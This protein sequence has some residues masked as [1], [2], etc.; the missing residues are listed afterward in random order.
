[1]PLDGKTPPNSLLSSPALDVQGRVS[2]NGRWLAYASDESGE[3]EVYVTQFPP[4]GGKWQLSNGGGEAPTWRRDGKELFFLTGDGTLMAIPVRTDGVFEHD[5]PVAL[6]KWTVRRATNTFWFYDA[7]PDG[8][9]F[10]G[11]VPLGERP[12]AELNVI[13]NWR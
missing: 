7:M 8:K 5:K 3:R 12:T 6:F 1:M 4:A 11:V 10:V 9:Q 13:V 2:P